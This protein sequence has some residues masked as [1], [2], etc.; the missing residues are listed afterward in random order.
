MKT[1]THVLYAIVGG[2]LAGLFAGFLVL[3]APCSWFGSSFEGACG[4]GAVF[5]ALLLGMAVTLIAGTAILVY[6]L[7][8]G[9]ELAPPGDYGSSKSAITA[10]WL[11][12]IAQYLGFVP[13]I[14]IYLAGIVGSAIS[15]VASI[16]FV[17][18]SA[19]IAQARGMRPAIALA[20][21]I[22]LVGPMITG[23]LLF[24]RTPART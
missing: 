2:A 13:G 3:M 12:L 5:A 6:L 10:W 24:R 4:Y 9:K 20:A 23:V 18:L 14:N 11:T 7:G 15:L 22:P 8:R 1:F 21:I 17:G 19:A 16:V